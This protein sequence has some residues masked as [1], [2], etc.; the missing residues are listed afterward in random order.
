MSGCWF[1]AADSDTTSLNFADHLQNIRRVWP[2]L[3]LLVSEEFN[4]GD[5]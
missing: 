3:E 5:R 4:S 2:V 1:A